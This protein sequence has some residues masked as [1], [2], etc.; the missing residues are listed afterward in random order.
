MCSK[1]IVVYA[2]M[3]CLH[4]MYNITTPA[5]CDKSTWMYAFAQYTVTIIHIC[6]HIFITHA[7]HPGTFLVYKCVCTHLHTLCTRTQSSYIRARTQT[8]THAHTSPQAHTHTHTHA[9]TRP[10]ARMHAHART[11]PHTHTNVH[12]RIRSRTFTR[13]Q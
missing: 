7:S 1:S 9:R 4:T 3:H 13:I 6:T 5:T 8:R 2:P 10:H 12:A 11:R